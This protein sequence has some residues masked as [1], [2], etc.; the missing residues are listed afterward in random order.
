MLEGLYIYLVYG[1]RNQDDSK[2]VY[3]SAYLSLALSLFLSLLSIVN[4]SCL[5]IL[6]A[7]G[8]C[9]GIKKEL[10]SGMGSL[11]EPSPRRIARINRKFFTEGKKKLKGGSIVIIVLYCDHRVLPVRLSLL[12]SHKPSQFVSWLW[13]LSYILTL[14]IYKHIYSLLQCKEVEY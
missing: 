4:K 9:S 7:K 8:I 3:I 2:Q 6:T 14:Y 5:G 10:Q 11:G 12:G 1:S 13:T